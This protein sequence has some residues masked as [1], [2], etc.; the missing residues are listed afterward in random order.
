MFASAAR[1]YGSSSAGLRLGLVV[2]PAAQ[3]VLAKLTSSSYLN[4]QAIDSEDTALHLASRSAFDHIVRLLLQQ[5]GV[6]TSL[7]NRAGQLAYEVAANDAVR[8]VGS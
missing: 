2:C 7:R 5:Q 4:M 1:L 6:N 3:V 8:Q